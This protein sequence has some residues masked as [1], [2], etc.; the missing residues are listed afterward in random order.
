MAKAC[1]PCLSPRVKELLSSSLGSDY[2]SLRPLLAGIA[3]CPPGGKLLELCPAGAGGARVK[4][5]PSAYN[6]WIGT[7]MKAKNIKGFG[8]AAPAMKA[9]AAEWKRQKGR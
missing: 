2:P 3:D 4:R 5:A 8:N 1:T 7:C 6:A 9:C